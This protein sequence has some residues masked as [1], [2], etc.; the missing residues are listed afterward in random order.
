MYILTSIFYSDIADVH[1]KLLSRVKFV[2]MSVA[3]GT[4][5]GG[6]EGGHTERHFTG[7]DIRGGGGENS[8]FWRLHCNVLA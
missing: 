1:L 3:A 8:E 2:T 4:G 6:R 5:N 7:G